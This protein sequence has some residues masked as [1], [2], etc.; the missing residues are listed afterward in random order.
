MPK[1]GKEN[2]QKTKMNTKRN[3][4]MMAR[5]ILL[6]LL[7]LIATTTAWADVRISEQTFP[8]EQF[9]AF[10]LAQPYGEDGVLTDDEIAGVTFMFATERGFQ[11]LEGIK[12]FT[13]LSSLYCSGNQLTELDVAGMTSLT[14]LTCSDN[15]LASLNVAGCPQLTR[16]DLSGNQLRGEAM[17]ALILALPDLS[18]TEMLGGL[19][20]IFGGSDGNKMTDAQVITA[21]KKGWATYYNNGGNWFEKEPEVEV[22]ETAFPD[23]NF[24]NYLRNQFGQTLSSDEILNAKYISVNDL[25][26]KSLT[27]IEFFTSLTTLYC[28]NNQLAQL[29]LSQNTALTTLYC[30]NNRLD[31]LDLSKNPLLTTLSIYQNLIKGEAMDALIESLP[32]LSSSDGGLMLALYDANEGNVL[33][34]TQVAALKAK[35]WLPRRGQNNAWTE[36]EGS[37]ED[38][39]INEETFPDAKFRAWVLAQAYGGDGVL[40]SAE[41]PAITKIDV[42]AQ[43]IQS[44]QGIEHFAK[45][46]TLYCADNQLA[47]LDLSRNP[48]LQTLSCNDNQL[49]ALDL[50][51]CRSLSSLYCYQN[52]IGEEAMDDLVESLPSV[53]DWEG[54]C[55]Y[56]ING[57]EDKNVI[58]TLQVA[59][60][61]AKSWQ[62]KR[63]DDTLSDWVDYAGSVPIGIRD[64]EAQPTQDDVW[65]DLSGRRLPGKPTQKGVYINKGKKVG[66]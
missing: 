39:V 38:V 1:S 53:N 61:K 46:T 51:A 65:Y 13:S 64:I 42:S 32:D 19:Y 12:C 44:L 22:N 16:I 5:R 57:N 11:S 47:E 56:V 18:S 21:R 41:I 15:R 34:Y 63:W 10:V 45:L 4:S 24:R 28:Y 58:N 54:G 2:G 55:L 37:G 62:T 35:G 36:Y 52:L 27:G 40:Q 6:P 50:S 23:P 3:H 60:A 48:A 20:A 14:S 9:R 59:A 29:D 7:T 26:I 8:D 17:D 25:G 33:N 43:G 30:Y 31:A 66:L 49:T